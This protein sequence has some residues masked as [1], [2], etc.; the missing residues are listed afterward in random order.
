MRRQQ[1]GLGTYFVRA[2]ARGVKGVE[3]RGRQLDNV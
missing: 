3:R 1:Y 2:V